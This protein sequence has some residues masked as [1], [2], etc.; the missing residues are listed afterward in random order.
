M[1]AAE[2]AL[3]QRRRKNAGSD[4]S[5][6]KLVLIGEGFA[7][8]GAEQKPTCRR[9]YEQMEIVML[10]RDQLIREYQRRGG[11]FATLVGIYLALLA[12]LGVT[13]SAIV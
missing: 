11:S 6:A 2:N 8:S 3:V 5:P 12:V 4:A 1:Q 7:C 9:S 10:T 13:A